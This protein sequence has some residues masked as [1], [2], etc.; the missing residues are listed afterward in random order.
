[1]RWKEAVDK[2]SKELEEPFALE[3]VWRNLTELSKLDWVMLMREEI[4]E[5]ELSSLTVLSNRLKHHEPPHYI[6]G[7]SEFCDLRFK[8]DERVL[9]PRPETEELVKLILDQNENGSQSVIDIGTGSGAIAISLAKVR[10]EWKMTASDISIGALLIAREN[11]QT[12]HVSIK[13][14]KKDVL[15]KMTG[16]FDLIVSN[17][18]YIARSDENEV[19]RSVKIY[20]PDKALFAEHQG[21]AI[22]EKIACQAPALLTKG[23]KIYLEIGYKQGT[24]VKTLFETAFPEKTVTIHIDSFGKERMISVV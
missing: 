11:A 15:D 21:L 16:K 18:P 17:P 24:A 12:H 1:M 3:F 5:K 6:I 2:L 9:I 22:Y 19:D 14:D 8:V 10:P 23:G 13:F 7:W 20:E 4:S